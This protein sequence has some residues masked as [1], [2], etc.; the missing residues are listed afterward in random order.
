MVLHPQAQ[1]Q[2]QQELDI[3]LG[4][5]GLPRISDRERLPYMRNLIDEVLRLYP[6]GPLGKHYLELFE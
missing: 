5:A 2:A 6:I 3:V 4:Q 1:A